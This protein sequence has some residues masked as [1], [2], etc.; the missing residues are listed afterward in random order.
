MGKKSAA[1]DVRE[2]VALAADGLPAAETLVKLD[3]AFSE[4][5]SGNCKKALLG[6]HDIQFS[7]PGL[8]GIDF[9]VGYASYLAGEPALSREF[10]QTAIAKKELEVEAAAIL[11]LVDYSTSDASQESSLSD[12]VTSVESALGR[13]A[14]HD[15]LDPRAHYFYAEMLRSKGSYRSASEL[16]ARALAKMD[17]RF[18]ARIIEAKMTLSRLQNQRPAEVPPVSSSESLDGPGSV[19]AAYA[20]LVNG[21]P[22]EAVVFLH[23][24]S[25]LYPGIL[26]SELM[27]DQAFDEFRKDPNLKE[28][29]SSGT[30]P[31]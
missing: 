29:V 25:E 22:D 26:F 28:F 8:Y 13:Y 9:L 27:R 30:L 4:L 31:R 17:P 12:P 20:A 1:K 11:A 16:M 14:M 23:R 7:Q 15:P 5:R 6:F 10:C 18:D 21:K 2:P 24:V 19:A 3:A